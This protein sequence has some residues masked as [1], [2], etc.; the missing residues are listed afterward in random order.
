[1][2]LKRIA[3]FSV[4]AMSMLSI[5]FFMYYEMNLDI[6][7]PQVDLQNSVHI[8]ENKLSEFQHEAQ[9]QFI[10]PVQEAVRRFRTDT[11]LKEKDDDDVPIVGEPPIEEEHKPILLGV[12]EQE[13]DKVLFEHHE[14]TPETPET[15]QQIG[16][17]RE[18]GKDPVLVMD[19]HQRKALTKRGVLK[20]GGQER[21]SEVIYWKIVPGDITYESP[22]TP[23]HGLHHD[24]YLT[25]EYDQGGWNNI[26]MGMEVFIVIAHAMGRTLVLPPAQNLYL[27][28]QKHKGIYI[29][30]FCIYL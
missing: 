14:E 5:A 11:L 17:D 2:S 15:P 29:F 1:M 10:D 30:V 24:R 8:I 16:N 7:D 21:D 25:F 9:L 19:K 6:Q 12:A 18:N 3:I 28:Y 23:H 4:V 26:R 27:L 22:I 13:P 20:C